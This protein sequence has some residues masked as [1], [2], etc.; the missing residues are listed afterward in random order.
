MRGKPYKCGCE[1]ETPDT[2]KVCWKR[3]VLRAKR[4][5]NPGCRVEESRAYLA[6][7]GPTL[8]ARSRARYALDPTLKKISCSKHHR[9]SGRFKLSGHTAEY[10]EL[11][12]AE[13][14][15]K[16]SICERDFTEK[17]S[18][19]PAADHNHSTQKPRGILC[20][21]CNSGLGWLEHSLTE[22]MLAYLEMWSDKHLEGL[23]EQGSELQ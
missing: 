23:D 17:G 8:N 19:R 5:A 18:S 1:T 4:K 16:C 15:G 20:L 22:K 9:N 14:G 13:Q 7:Y 6:K 3:S 21:R 10:F 12:W 2:C 11:M